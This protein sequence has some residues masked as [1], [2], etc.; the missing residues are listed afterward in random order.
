MSCSQAR[1]TYEISAPAKI[2]WFLDILDKRPDG[3][4]NLETLMQKISLS[5]K[6]TVSFD[7][8]LYRLEEDKL[9]W[10]DRSLK[11]GG[12]EVFFCTK[13]DTDDGEDLGPVQNNT[14]IKALDFYLKAHP[15]LAAVLPRYIFIHLAKEIP[16]QAGLG[17][18]SSDGAALL[19]LMQEVSLNLGQDVL[20]CQTLQSIALQVG[21]DVP[22]LTQEAPLALCKGVGEIISPLDPAPSLPILLIKPD[23]QISTAEAFR[24]IDRQDAQSRKQSRAEDFYEALLEEDYLDLD[25]LGQNTFYRLSLKEHPILDEIACLLEESGALF[26]SMSGS[27]PTLFGLFGSEEEACVAEADLRSRLNMKVFRARTLSQPAP[28]PGLVDRTL[29]RQ[30]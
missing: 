17:G 7:D 26:C 8:E 12:K 19:S 27:G 29:K 20:D 10:P 13:T 23:I 24:A 25:H 3:Y 22:F 2:N 9:P 6:L 16:S 5:D 4:H 14:V 15:T 1:R 18:G 30:V 21:A 11:L 28:G